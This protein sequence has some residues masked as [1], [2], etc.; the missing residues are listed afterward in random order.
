[1][2]ARIN[3]ISKSGKSAHVS[4]E[5]GKAGPF[6][7]TIHGWA[8]LPDNHDLA[9]KQEVDVPAKGCHTEDMVFE[10]GETMKKIVWDM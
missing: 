6:L 8:S 9:V 4:V 10:G 7:N 1:M 5:L 3:Y 2:K